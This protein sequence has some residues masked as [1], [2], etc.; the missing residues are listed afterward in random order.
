MTP[1][2]HFTRPLALA[3]CLVA[4]AISSGLQAKTFRVAVG[5]GAGGTQHELGLKFVEEFKA[6]T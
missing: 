4:A 3:L 5:D 1:R 2:K 6:R